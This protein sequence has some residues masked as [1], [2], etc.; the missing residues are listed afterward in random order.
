MDDN[1][2]HIF[3]VSD[4]SW[5]YSGT[6]LPS[7]LATSDYVEGILPEGEKWDPGYTYTYVNGVATRGAKVEI[8]DL[9]SS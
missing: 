9:E 8:I 3:K 4:G 1:Y 2:M 5:I 6:M 7:N